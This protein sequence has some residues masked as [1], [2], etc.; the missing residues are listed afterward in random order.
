MEKIGELTYESEFDVI[1][2]GFEPEITYPIQDIEHVDMMYEI[3]I[4]FS[5]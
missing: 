1:A 5:R 3:A 4:Q 2:T